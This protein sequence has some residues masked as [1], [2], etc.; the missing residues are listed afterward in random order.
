MKHTVP[1]AI[2]ENLRP[3]SS[4]SLRLFSWQRDLSDVE[5]HLESGKIQHYD[6]LGNTWHYHPEVELN[7]MLEGS[8]LLFVGDYVG[9][10]Q[11]PD[12]VLLGPN[13]P[14][15]WKATGTV[16]GIAM[17]FLSKEGK[18]SQLP[19]IKSLNPL[20]SSSQQGLRFSGAALQSIIKNMLPLSKASELKRLA[21]CLNLLAQLSEHKDGQALLSTHA[22]NLSAHKHDRMSRV[23]DS[24]LRNFQQNLN[25]NDALL[26]SGLSRATF[27]RQFKKTTGATFT[28]YLNAVRLQEARRLLIETEA[29][30]TSIAFDTGFRNLSHFNA[31]FKKRFNCSPKQLRTAYRQEA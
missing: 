20:L 10:F 7:L 16:K 23:I 3:H 13:L 18:L 4:Q 31:L 6:G 25:L 1:K 17:Q 29:S 26:L 5:V 9:H 14:H 21:S 22:M 2:F 19:E 30:I 28:A 12:A 27:H 15:Y 11:A 8:G 24:I